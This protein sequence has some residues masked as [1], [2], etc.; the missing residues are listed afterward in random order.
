MSDEKI[1]L[2]V[3][4][5]LP[6]GKCHISF[7]EYSDWMACS[8]RHKLKNIDK[9][10]LDRPGPALAFGTAIHHACEM[11]VSKREPMFENFMKK[12]D[13]EWE[14]CLKHP[15][16]IIESFSFTEK[17]KLVTSART[18]CEDFPSFLDETFPEWEP[19]ATEQ[20]L[21]ESIDGH[22]DVKFKGYIDCIIKSKSKNKWK[23]HVLDYKTCSW[24]WSSD[25]KQ[26][27]ITSAQLVFY[28][29]YWALK[30]GI[31]LKDISC[32]FILL[33]K[34]AKPGSSCGIVKVSVG[35]ITRERALK[36]ASK[37]ITAVKRKLAFKNRSESNCKWCQYNNTEHCTII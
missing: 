26:D 5:S 32:A 16:L 24:G 3:V 10:D 9:V 8:W 12:F 30:A 4:Q 2:S 18:I 23:Y 15:R 11:W 22:E 35:D 27:P 25:K 14:K 19:I 20:N 13:E 21:Y 34:I 29:H 1:S 7:S 17:S 36:N 33:K 37:M 28:K 31:P 6:T